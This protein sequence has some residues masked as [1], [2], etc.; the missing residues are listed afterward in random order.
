MYVFPCRPILASLCIFAV[1]AVVSMRHWARLRC[2]CAA[3]PFSQQRGRRDYER[4]KG[5]HYWQKYIY[6]LSYTHTYAHTRSR[7]W[8]FCKRLVRGS[9][10][11]IR[12]CREE[13]HCRAICCESNLNVAWNRHVQSVFGRNKGN[14]NWSKNNVVSPKEDAATQTSV[15]CSFYAPSFQTKKSSGPHTDI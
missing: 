12:N 10:I 9:E 6:T 1:F 4:E 11:I 8:F 2:G 13:L 3:F 5:R 15:F 14:N 7:T